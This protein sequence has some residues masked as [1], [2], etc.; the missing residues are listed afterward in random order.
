[1]RNYSGSD[2]YETPLDRRDGS[3]DP[4][5]VIRLWQL[6]IT[7]REI[8]TRLQGSRGVPFTPDAICRVVAQMRRA[9][10]RR[11]VARR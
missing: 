2:P 1:M 9:G 4:E 8:G 6:G 10:D 7:A 5:A 11:A 3:I